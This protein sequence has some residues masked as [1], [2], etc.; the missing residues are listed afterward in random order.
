MTTITERA[1]NDVTGT[2]YTVISHMREGYLVHKVGCRDIARAERVNQV[3]DQHG[4]MLIVV[5]NKEIQALDI[6]GIVQCPLL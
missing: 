2:E 1:M 6:I 3:F 4:H 5:D